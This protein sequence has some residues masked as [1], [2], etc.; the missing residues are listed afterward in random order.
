MKMAESQRAQKVGH[1]SAW[2]YGGKDTD[3]EPVGLALNPS[4]VPQDP[5]CRQ[6]PS[7]L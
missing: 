7:L 5:S 1:P 4:S 2:G 3:L 6:V